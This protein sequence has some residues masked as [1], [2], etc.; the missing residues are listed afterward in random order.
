MKGWNGQSKVHSQ[1][2]YLRNPFEHWF[3]N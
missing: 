2:G 3:G 1:W